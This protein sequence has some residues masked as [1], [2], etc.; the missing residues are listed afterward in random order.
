MRKPIRD[1]KAGDRTEW[2]EVLT[3]VGKLAGGCPV[4]DLP[5]IGCRVRYADGGEGE[6]AWPSDAADREIEVQS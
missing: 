1:L 3:D 6:R 4:V 5:L 2:Y